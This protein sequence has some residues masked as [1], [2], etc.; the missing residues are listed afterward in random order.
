MGDTTIP[1]SIRKSSDPLRASRSIVISLDDALASEDVHAR[2]REAEASYQQTLARSRIMLSEI[3]RLRSDP[4]LRW[5]LAEHVENLREHMENKWHFR[6][7]NL[8]SALSRDLGLSESA[9]N[10]ALR[11]RTRFSRNE[12]SQ[13]GVNWSKFQE[14]LDIKSD[15]EMKRCFQMVKEGKL[16]GDSEIRTFKKKA[17]SAL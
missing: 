1:V 3:K 4:L 12:V 11:L 13:S 2:I 8:A 15:D 16:Q 10:Y 14:L 7:A 5:K 6:P 9:L 17:N